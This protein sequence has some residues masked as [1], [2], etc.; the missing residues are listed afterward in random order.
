MAFGFDS[1]ESSKRTTEAHQ[2]ETIALILTGQAALC[3]LV[4][5]Y[6]IRL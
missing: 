6:N 1:V 5:P 3:D 2:I 4:L